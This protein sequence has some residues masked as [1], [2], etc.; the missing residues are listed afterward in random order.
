GI[1]LIQ[2]STSKVLSNTI[3]FSISLLILLPTLRNA[4]AQPSSTEN[5]PHLR[6]AFLVLLYVDIIHSEYIL[7][8]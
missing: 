4:K 8:I 5:A 6:K 2:I 7:V 1:Y 3:I